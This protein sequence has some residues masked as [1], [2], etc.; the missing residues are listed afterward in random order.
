MT[1]IAGDTRPHGLSFIDGMPD[2]H[3]DGVAARTM[4]VAARNV[5]SLPDI[6]ID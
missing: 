3:P 2:D 1:A 5:P 4:I 6:R